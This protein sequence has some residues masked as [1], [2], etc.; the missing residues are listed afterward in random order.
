MQRTSI[1]NFRATPQLV[2]AINAA[3]AQG[4]V[5]VSE[6]VRQAVEDRIARCESNPGAPATFDPFDKLAAAA[7]GGLQ[8]Q[9][10]LANEAV[11]MAF[12]RDETGQFVNNPETCMTEG[13]I[14]ARLAAAHGELADQG[15]VISMLALLLEVCGEEG[16]ED[17]AA[18]CVARISMV[19]DQAGANPGIEM[20][21]NLMPQIAEG[22][23][24]EAMALAKDYTARIKDLAAQ[25][26]R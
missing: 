20:A 9:R 25:G 19:A 22:S 24:A 6:L 2:R 15:L 17:Q 11:R 8:A 21:A 3:A 14:L 7:R 4:G 16:F 5:T 13:L 12:E 18:E 1:V 26:A 10:D 23:S